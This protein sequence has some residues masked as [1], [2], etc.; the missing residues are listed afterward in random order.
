MI[1]NEKLFLFLK[2]RTCINALNLHFSWLRYTSD[3][4]LRIILDGFG[5]CRDSF[6]KNEKQQ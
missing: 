4:F 5:L 2:C 3:S 1:F 6:E